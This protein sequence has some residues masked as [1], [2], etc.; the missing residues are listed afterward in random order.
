MKT[1]P[2]LPALQELGA[3]VLA[4]ADTLARTVPTLLEALLRV[5]GSFT[6]LVHA[7]LDCVPPH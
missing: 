2:L 6:R 4:L 1:D 5:A 7:L 3:A